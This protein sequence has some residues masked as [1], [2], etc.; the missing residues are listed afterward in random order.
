MPSNLINT[1]HNTEVCEFWQYLP[2]L[3]I[4]I[5][6][7]SQYEKDTNIKTYR[8]IEKSKNTKIHT[9][10]PT[11]SHKQRSMDGENS[12]LRYF[13]VTAPIIESCS[14]FKGADLSQ[15]SSVAQSCPTLCDPMD[16]SMPGF[17]VLHHLPKLAK[18]MS[19]ESVVPFNH[20]TL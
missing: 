5:S 9:H 18:L 4:A 10:T 12:H 16:C 19:I 17:P 7:H 13:S 15:F 3:I 20:C 1:V 8:K 6:S 2:T 11:S 14:S